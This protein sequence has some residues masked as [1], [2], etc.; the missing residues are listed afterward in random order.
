M[1][2]KI[3]P[4][5]PGSC[6]FCV[7]LVLMCMSKCS[8][9]SCSF[10]RAAMQPLVSCFR[11]HHVCKDKSMKKRKIKDKTQPFLISVHTN[12]IRSFHRLCA[13]RRFT[14]SSNVLSSDP[15]LVLHVFFQTCC[16]KREAWYQARG[17]PL[18]AVTIFLNLLHNVAL[19]GTTAVV[20]W[21]FPG[22][23]DGL[24]RRVTSLYLERWVWFLCEVKVSDE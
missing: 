24:A 20:V 2:D 1:N 9:G 15:E 8:C 11:D 22:N 16:H 19:N 4:F 21:S 3:C 5:P 7:R 17:H 10:R 12:G 13:A 18:V 6:V 14:D 23:G